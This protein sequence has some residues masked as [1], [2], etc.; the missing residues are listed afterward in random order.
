MTSHLLQE[1]AQ[2]V[3]SYALTA[4][5]GGLAKTTEIYPFLA[6]SGGYQPRAEYQ[7]GAVRTMGGPIYQRFFL[8][9]RSGNVYALLDLEFRPEGAQVDVRC[10]AN[11]AAS[12]ILEPG[13][14]RRP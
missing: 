11:P 14:E 6:P 7:S 2:Y 12:R 13:R 4:V 10:L 3:W 9:S 5:N 1:G 8:Q